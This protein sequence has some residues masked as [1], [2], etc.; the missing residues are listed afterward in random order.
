MAPFI[1]YTVMTLNIR[2]SLRGDPASLAWHLRVEL[3]HL[4]VENA[5]PINTSKYTENGQNIYFLNI[6]QF[7]SVYFLFLF[8]KYEQDNSNRVLPRLQWK[9]RRVRGVSWRDKRGNW[10]L[11]GTLVGEQAAIWLRTGGFAGIDIS[12]RKFLCLEN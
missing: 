9:V 4:R 11:R 6:P 8:K 12:S 1:L 3:W 7:R 10:T 2:C 5:N